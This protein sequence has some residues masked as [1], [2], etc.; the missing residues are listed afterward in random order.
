[1]EGSASKRGTR[2]RALERASRLF[3]ALLALSAGGAL[4]GQAEFSFGFAGP[5]RLEALPGNS[6]G[7]QARSL[8]TTRGIDPG[9]A[10]AR[11]WSLS[12]AC[13][14]CRIAYAHIYGTVAE[15]FPQGLQR[16]GFALAALTEGAG[17]EGAVSACVL[18]FELPVTLEPES[19]PHEVL[20]LT[21]SAGAPGKDEPCSRARLYY[22]DGRR[23]GGV[24]FYN[25]V[26][27]GESVVRPF[28]ED[29]TVEVC[30]VFECDFAF[31]SSPVV[32]QRHTTPELFAGVAGEVT[33]RV[34]LGEVGTVEVHAAVVLQ[35]PPGTHS[36]PTLVFAWSLSVA[37][38][39]DLEVLDV[40]TSGT[41]AAGWPEG[42]N[43]GGFSV[44]Q[45]ADPRSIHPGTGKPQGQGFV[46][47]C[48]LGGGGQISLPPRGTST[49]VAILLGA[50]AEQG[51]TVQEGELVWFDGMTGEGLPVNNLIVLRGASVDLCERRPLKVRFVPHDDFIRCDANE[52]GRT[53]I[54]DV[55]SMLRSLFRSAGTASCA[56]DCNASGR[57]DIADPIFLVNHLFRGGPAP[58]APYPSCGDDPDEPRG[59]RGS[60]ACR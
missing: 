39:G 31:Q 23:S 26:A 40:T 8:L 5:E 49:L 18:S 45:R 35:L 30:S 3:G 22:T 48:Y 53:D 15:P 56:A 20:R 7:F 25:E 36:Q 34:P 28:L 13:D 42:L 41:V 10:G 24:P 32:E 47:A 11:A 19:S 33:S 52:D 1:M 29:K 46:S 2:R 57:A 60:R 27:H 54:S 59:C 9:E 58:K 14:G 55:I 17:N 51:D 4:E 44:A 16:G 6:V 50:A 12:L 37:A 43:R 38:R 21:V